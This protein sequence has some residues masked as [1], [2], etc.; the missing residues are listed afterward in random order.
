MKIYGFETIEPMLKD[1]GYLFKLIANDYGVV[2]FPH[3]VEHRDATQPNI[4]YADDSLG[5]ALAAMVKPGRIEFRYHN[6]FTDERVRLLVK[7]LLTLRE[8]AFASNFTVTYQ[9]RDV[10]PTNP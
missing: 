6:Q 10:T 2:L 5:N 3:N 9:S 1:D 7:R 4:K 8:L